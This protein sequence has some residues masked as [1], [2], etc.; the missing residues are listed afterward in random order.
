MMTLKLEL[1]DEPTP[2]ERYGTVRATAEVE[3]DAER[4]WKIYQSAVAAATVGLLTVAA[5]DAAA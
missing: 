3:V 2:D 1:R 4:A 5:P